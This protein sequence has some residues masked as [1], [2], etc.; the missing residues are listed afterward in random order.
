MFSF[1][2]SWCRKYDD[3][4]SLN[5]D[6]EYTKNAVMRRCWS[7]PPKPPKKSS[8]CEYS[9]WFI[10]WLCSGLV[11]R[12]GP[13]SFARYVYFGIIEILL[14]DYKVVLPST[15]CFLCKIVITILWENG[16]LNIWKKRLWSMSP[17]Y[18]PTLLH[19]KKDSTKNTTR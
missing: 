3:W 13:Y 17:D 18:P 10:L 6:N 19:G 4:I 2:Y 16:M 12:E 8:Q 15:K 1:G 11:V 5:L 9:H 7:Y 14:R